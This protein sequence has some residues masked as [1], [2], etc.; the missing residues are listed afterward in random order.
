MGFSGL[1]KGIMV[2]MI[3]W[4]ILWTVYL[5][6]I[7]PWGSPDQT[8]VQILANYSLDV[9]TFANSIF[10]AVSFIDFLIILPLVTVFDNR[11]Y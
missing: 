1:A 5:Y 7:N 4:M 2:S 8:I 10:I 3:I 9:Y 11:R 6:L